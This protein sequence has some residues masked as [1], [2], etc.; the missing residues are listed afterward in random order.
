VF[1]AILTSVRLRV[2][3][4]IQPCDSTW[5]QPPPPARRNRLMRCRLVVDSGA[6]AGA[7]PGDLNPPASSRSP[8]AQSPWRP[9]GRFGAAM[10][11]K[12]WPWR[13]TSQV[14]DQ[15]LCCLGRRNLTT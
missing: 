1:P 14:V 12:A 2:C 3:R 11:R 6:Q 7:D 5:L 13:G 15:V 8:I 10:T 9:D 4:G